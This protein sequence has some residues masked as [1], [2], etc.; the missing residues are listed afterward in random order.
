MPRGKVIGVRRHS[1]GR[2]DPAVRKVDRHVLE[3]HR[4]PVHDDR[5]HPRDL[6]IAQAVLDAETD[7]P[8][9]VGQAAEG[10]ELLE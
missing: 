1:G 3:A 6:G 2:R 8:F 7:P 10:V 9:H 5:Q 4:D